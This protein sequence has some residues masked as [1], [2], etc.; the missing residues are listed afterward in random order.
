MNNKFVSDKTRVN[1]R[2][3]AAVQQMSLAGTNANRADKASLGAAAAAPGGR[4]P[5]AGEVQNVGARPSCLSD[6]TLRKWCF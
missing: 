4:K 3:K 2:E 5:H 1:E 6:N